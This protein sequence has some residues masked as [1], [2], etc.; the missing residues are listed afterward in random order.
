MTRFLIPV[1][2]IAFFIVAAAVSHDSN[3]ATAS[4]SSSADKPQRDFVWPPQVGQRFPNVAFVDQHG[5]TVHLQDLQGRILLIEPIGMPCEACQAFVGG[6]EHGGFGGVQPQPD[7][8]SIDE[9]ARTYGGVDL[10]DPRILKV[11]LLL[12]SLDMT[13]PAAKDAQRWADHFGIANS[14]DH[15]VLA[16]NDSLLDADTFRLIPGFWLVDE[17]FVVRAD[18]C[19][20]HSHDDLY[21]DLLPAL[22]PLLNE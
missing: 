12:F 3:S 7:M 17:D 2:V 16:G 8:P 10:N 21:R 11:Q 4:T 20:H 13:A 1:G 19:G 22:G 9:L 6:H 15:L 5:T 14:A 18:S